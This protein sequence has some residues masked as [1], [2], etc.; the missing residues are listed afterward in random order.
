MI[1]HLDE[2][3]VTKPI[4]EGDGAYV[5]APFVPDYSLYVPIYIKYALHT[6]KMKDDLGLASLGFLTHI[7][8]LCR[9]R[10]AHVY[11]SFMCLL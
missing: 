11:T 3:K 6:N 7:A 4:C 1:R 10:A 2:A 5:D 8:E 9:L